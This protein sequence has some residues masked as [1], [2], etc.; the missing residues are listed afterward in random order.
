MDRLFFRAGSRYFGSGTQFT[1]TSGLNCTGNWHLP[2]TSPQKSLSGLCPLRNALF[3]PVHGKR[4]PTKL[5]HILISLG[6]SSEI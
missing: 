4:S 1:R 3:L 5:N 6:P 2:T